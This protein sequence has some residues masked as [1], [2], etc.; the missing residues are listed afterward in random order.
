MKA[1]AKQ[2]FEQFNQ[3]YCGHATVE[4]EAARGQFSVHAFDTALLM[5]SQ[6]VV[7]YQRREFYKISLYARGTTQLECAG[8]TLFIDRPSL[9]FYNPLLPHSCQNQTQL[10]G[11]YCQFTEEFLHGADRNASLQESPL[12]NLNA[13]PLFHLTDEA[14]AQLSR[15]FQNMITDIASDYRHKYDL[16]RTHVQQLVHTALRLQPE[17]ALAPDPGSTKQLA[18]QFLHL[19]EQQFPIMSPTQPLPL[20]TAQDFAE[21]LCIHIN[22]LNRAVRES[23]GKTTSTHVSERI[24]YGAQ[25]LLRHTNWPIADIASSLGFAETSYFSRFFRKQTGV[26]PSRFRQ[27]TS[28]LSQKLDVDNARLTNRV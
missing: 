15:T 5:P 9:M 26:S 17:P 3:Q 19:L 27:S 4:E 21:Q 8:Q 10:A 22:Y 18:T 14:A 2:S 24:A 7:P 13:C 20:R 11:Y 12:F 6:L 23:T 28:R 1:A 16:L 25:S